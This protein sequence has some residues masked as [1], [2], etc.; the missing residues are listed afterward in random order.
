IIVVARTPDFTK[1][2]SVQIIFTVEDQY[3]VLLLADQWHTVRKTSLMTHPTGIKAKIFVYILATAIKAFMSHRF[4]HETQIPPYFLV[5]R[6]SN[7]SCNSRH[8]L[9]F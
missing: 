2:L 4:D 1:R 7:Y 5:R 6:F 8:N 3:D 9:D